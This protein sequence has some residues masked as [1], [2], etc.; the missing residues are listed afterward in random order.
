LEAP[1]DPPVPAGAVVGGRDGAT[2]RVAGGEVRFANALHIVAPEKAE[3]ESLADFATA[4]SRRYPYARRWMIWGEPSRHSN[5]QPMPAN[6]PDAPRR[7]AKILDAAYG[8]LKAQSRGNIV[9]GGMTYTAGDVTPAD[10]TRWM[11]LPSGRPPRLDWWGH[12]P[13]STRFPNLKQRPLSNFVGWRDFSDLDRR[14]FAGVY[15]TRLSY[16][17]EQ[18]GRLASHLEANFALGEFA[19]IVTADHGQCPTVDLA[20]GVRLDPIQLQ[21]DIDREFG[22]S[23]FGLVSSVVPSEV[24]LNERAMWDAGVTRDDV[25]AFLRDYRYRDN[26]G[27]YVNRDAIDF[28]RL[29]QRPFAAVLSTDYIEALGGGD[30]S[31]FGPGA[32][33]AESDPGIPE[34]TW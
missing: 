27:P 34:I 20:E 14:H 17:D 4:A 8:A 18:L 2:A 1:T 19:L 10:W 6:K 16:T 15:D 21:E 33:F 29:D 7:Y 12:N 24:Y 23:V 32:F 3:A 5:F 30:L 25:A 11:R 9:I 13:F 31:R 22:G 28:G 26:I